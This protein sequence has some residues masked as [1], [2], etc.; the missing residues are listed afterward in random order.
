[1]AIGACIHWSRH[2]L[3]STARDT[4]EGRR[5]ASSCRSQNCNRWVPSQGTLG[6]AESYDD[7]DEDDDTDNEHDDED[8]VEYHDDDQHGN[9]LNMTTMNTEG[10][11]R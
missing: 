9:V 1:M 11:G 3:R 8:D 2:R 6:D 5:S 7:K 4:V 10:T